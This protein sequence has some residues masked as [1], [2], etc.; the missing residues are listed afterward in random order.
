M[1]QQQCVHASLG[2]TT[3]TMA[4]ENGNDDNDNDMTWMASATVSQRRMM[5]DTVMDNTTTHDMMMTM[6][7]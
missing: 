4:G 5:H 2:K 6:T 1:P 7:M 3:T